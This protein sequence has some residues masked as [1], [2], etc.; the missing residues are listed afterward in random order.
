MKL[1]IDNFEKLDINVQEDI[2]DYLAGES[3][4]F[5]IEDFNEC[6]ICLKLESNLIKYDTLEGGYINVCKTCVKKINKKNK[7]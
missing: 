2:Q 3:I 4:D 6:D 1:V 7:K 5:E